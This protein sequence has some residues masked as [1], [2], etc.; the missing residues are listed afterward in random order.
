MKRVFFFLAV[1]LC[2]PLG[3]QQTYRAR[4]VDAETGEALPYV[5]VRTSSKAETLTNAEGDFAV[6]AKAKDML[7]FSL[8]GY[9]VQQVAANRLDSHVK[10]VPQTVSVQSLDE[11]IIDS[12]LLGASRRLMKT[13]YKKESINFRSTTDEN[14]SKCFS[15][16]EFYFYRY[17]CSNEEKEF[18]GEAIARAKSACNLREIEFLQKSFYNE[19]TEETDGEMP[20]YLQRSLVNFALQ[21]GPW[22]VDVQEWVTLHMFP[23]HRQDSVSQRYIL[24][25]TALK[26]SKGKRLYKIHMQ[27]RQEELDRW[28]RMNDG[29][30]EYKGAHVP[31]IVGDC[32]IVAGTLYLDE[33][34]SPVTFEG[35]L[36]EYGVE[37]LG[38]EWMPAKCHFHFDYINVKGHIHVKT[39]SATLEYGDIKS[40][41]LMYGIP[42]GKT[43]IDELP[44]IVLRTEAE[45]AAVTNHIN[46]KP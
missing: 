35:D 41:A 9:E 34:L 14:R 15:M 19:S 3:A 6:K 11:Q 2:L 46:T 40:H 30:L 13:I 1:L 12:L 42:N 16:T 43:R 31:Y 5:N 8:V 4:V 39:A 32:G 29:L 44:S 10:M 36:M 27:P 28:P 21:L 38:K 45:A 7:A 26:S 18:L 23:L 22:V 37:M 33:D 25:G 20:L 17:V 24:S